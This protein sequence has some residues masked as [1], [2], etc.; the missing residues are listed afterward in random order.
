MHGTAADIHFGNYRRLEIW[1]QTTDKV[2]L[3]L[4]WLTGFKDHILPESR[5]EW[6]VASEGVTRDGCYGALI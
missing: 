3:V 2:V 4:V 1:D 5:N 6:Q